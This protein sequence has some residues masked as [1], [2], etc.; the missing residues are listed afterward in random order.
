MIFT[1]FAFDNSFVWQYYCVLFSLSQLDIMT[2]PKG[3]QIRT[4]LL[5]AGVFSTSG[6]VC[7]EFKSSLLNIHINCFDR[8]H[9]L[10]I[11]YT[12]ML[13]ILHTIYIH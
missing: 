2:Q 7:L 9:F 3:R 10:D 4:L 12:N 1:R 5:I 8:M 11:I 6:W 13:Y